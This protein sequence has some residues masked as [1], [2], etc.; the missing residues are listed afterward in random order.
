MNTQDL[1]PSGDHHLIPGY[2]TTPKRN[3]V[4]PH[5]PCSL[6]HGN[7]YVVLCFWLLS[8]SAMFSRC[9]H[10]VICQYFIPFYGSIIFHWRIYNTLLI[11]SSVGGHLGY[12][13]LLAPVNSAS[14]NTGVF[15]VN[16]GIYLGVELLDHMVTLSL[17]FQGTAKLLSS[18]HIKC[19]CHFI[20]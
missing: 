4:L 16:L 20:F 11:H 15:C 19:L 18:S 14:T 7:P 17:A 8:L 12:S 9:I 2:S 5:S 10:I 13:H 1:S 6:I 3:P